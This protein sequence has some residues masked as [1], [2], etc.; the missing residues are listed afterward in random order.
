METITFRCSSC[1]HTLRVSA[2]KA[3]R[4]VRCTKCD[5]VVTVPAAEERVKAAAPKPPPTP[6][7]PPPAPPKPPDAQPPDD[8][9][10]G[11]G[12]LI[13]PKEEAEKK[14]REAEEKKRAKEAGKKKPPKLTKR[15][16]TIYDIDEWK[17]VNAGLLFFLIGIGLWGLGYLLN[18]VGVLMGCLEGPQ[19]ASLIP[20]FLMAEEQPPIELGH[21]QAFT[22]VRFS[23]AMLS[24]EG[25][26]DL[27]SI[28]LIINQVALLGMGIVFLI[29]Y[30]MCLPVPQRFGTKIQVKFLIVISIINLVFTLTLKLLPLVG[31]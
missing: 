28:M 29:G 13:D 24:G 10:K 25:Q 2:E 17:K 9:K 27:V 30:F 23:I 12:L 31:A 19:Y 8:D 20:K 3:G 5:E 18:G 16:K 11:Y 21:L 1:D 4:R 6:T 7:K 26:F 22:R 15:R 14:K